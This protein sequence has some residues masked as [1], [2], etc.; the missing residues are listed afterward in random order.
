MQGICN[1]RILQK[2]PVSRS[3]QL[4]GPVF[5]ISLAIGSNRE[6]IF[7]YFSDSDCVGQRQRGAGG[8]ES[9]QRR[10]PQE[11][12]L[13]G[14][15]GGHPGAR[16]HHHRHDADGGRRQSRHVV[17]RQVTDLVFLSLK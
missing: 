3:L 5:F 4:Q 10:E 2:R 6:R 12:K 7:N 14:E 13:L 16:G 8:V 17:L 15:D 11:P 9:R 1:C